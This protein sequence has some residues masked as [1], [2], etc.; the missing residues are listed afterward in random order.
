[1]SIWICSNIRAVHGYGGNRRAPSQASRSLCTTTTWWANSYSLAQF[2]LGNSLIINIRFLLRS[3][4]RAAR[5]KA[6]GNGFRLR[7]RPCLKTSTWSATGGCSSKWREPRNWA[8]SKA[9][10]NRIAS[11]NW[12]SLLKRIK[13]P[14]RRTLET[15]RGTKRSYCEILI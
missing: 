9:P 3:I 6:R 4:R 13:R 11:S 1:M 2:S 5:F 10:W 8:E 14:W 7:A 15:R 12:T